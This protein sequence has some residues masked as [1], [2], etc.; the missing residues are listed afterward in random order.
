MIQFE[1]MALRVLL[2]DESST[3]KKVMQLALQD[4]GVEVKSVPI[5]LDVLQVSKSYQP[6]IIFA[7]VLLSKRSG[8]DVSAEIK[9]DPALRNTPV[10]LMWSGFMEL[11]E[12]R[13]KASMAD[14][15]LE[16]PFDADQLRSLVRDLVPRLNENAISSYLSFPDLPEIMETPLPPPVQAQ[17]PQAPKPHVPM[18]EFNPK[19]L[20][21]GPAQDMDDPDDFQQ[22]PLPGSKTRNVLDQPSRRG[23]EE[24]P[25]RQGGLEQFRVSPDSLQL[26]DADVFADV[27]GASL[28]VTGQEDEMSMEQL[29]DLTAPPSPRSFASDSTSRNTL[30]PLDPMRAEEVLREQVREVL[31]SI[32]WKIIPDITERVVREEIQRLLKDSERLT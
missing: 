25:W 2:A 26:E 22:V 21:T 13:A 8:Y 32:A 10:V 16:K 19:D 31:E 11:D 7:D 20:L 17:R 27:S 23:D 9:G 30:P 24:E 6:D 28:A 18:H 3:I 4:F 5:G 12:A 14:R 29:E 1:Y 15:R